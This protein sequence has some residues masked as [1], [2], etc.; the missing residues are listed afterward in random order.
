M[1]GS[2]GATRD[3]SSAYDT[4]ASAKRANVTWWCC[5]P[6]AAPVCASTSFTAT[7]RPY[8]ATIF[9]ANWAIQHVGLVNVGFGLQAPAGVY[10]AGLASPLRDLTQIRLGRRWVIVAILAGASASWFVASSFAVASGVA[11]LV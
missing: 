2:A 11:F 4:A 5:R 6:A 8:I 9:A 1:S 3:C 10:F 7:A